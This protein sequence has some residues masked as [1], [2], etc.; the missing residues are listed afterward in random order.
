ML[1]LFL[2]ALVL[3]LVEFEGLSNF[4][5]QYFCKLL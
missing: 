5:A 1:I 3:V 2:P 4:N